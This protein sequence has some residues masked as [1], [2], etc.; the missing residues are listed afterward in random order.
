MS[1]TH[2]CSH[3]LL[4]ASDAFSRLP[5]PLLSLRLLLRLLLQHTQLLLLLL[6]PAVCL[7]E[8]LELQLSPPLFLG[9][10]PLQDLV[11]EPLL[12]LLL[13]LLCPASPPGLQALGL[14]PALL[15]LLQKTPGLVLLR[16]LV[17]VPLQ[18]VLSPLGRS[19]LADGLV[20][21]GTQSESCHRNPGVMKRRSAVPPSVCPA[22]GA[23]PQTTPRAASRPPQSLQVNKAL[24]LV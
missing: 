18:L 7:H 23:A 21:E 17:S 20:D 22:A 24:L 3:S 8:E 14:L 1:K 10:P 13:S 6:L 4:E 9:S 11:S 19:P 2:S 5:L 16:L 12:S 15:L